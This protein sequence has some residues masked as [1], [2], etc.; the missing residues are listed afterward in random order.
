MSLRGGPGKSALSQAGAKATN[1]VPQNCAREGTLT[2]GERLLGILPLCCWSNHLPEFR[3]WWSCDGPTVAK[4]RCATAE[5]ED[6]A[7]CATNNIYVVGQ[8]PTLN[9][10]KPRV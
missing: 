3:A 4:T 7:Q 9:T 6:L 1:S 5:D 8:T 2:S 10:K